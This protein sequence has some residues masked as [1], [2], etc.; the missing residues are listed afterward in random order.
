MS[1][2]ITENFTMFVISLLNLQDMMSEF[3]NH[4]LIIT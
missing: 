1:W 3:K 4:I 2:V